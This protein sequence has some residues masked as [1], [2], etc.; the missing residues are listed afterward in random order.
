[1]CQKDLAWSVAAYTIVY[2]RSYLQRVGN[3]SGEVDHSNVKKITKTTCQWVGIVKQRASNTNVNKVAFSN[4][5][6][7]TYVKELVL[8]NK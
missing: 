2:I 4:K 3:I 7:A 5:E 6:P 8:S 1:M